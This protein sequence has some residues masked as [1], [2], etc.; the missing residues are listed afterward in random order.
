[1]T[2]SAPRPATSAPSRA[3]PP[4]IAELGE[5]GI[6]PPKK[7]SG[8]F[9]RYPEAARRRKVK[10][11]VT[12]SLVISEAGVPEEL[13]VVESAGPVLDQAVLDAVS[14]WRF[15]PATREGRPV[16]LRYRVRQHFRL[17]S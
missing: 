1:L 9:A 11:V 2:P 4:S 17:E 16:R 12:V 10:G 7:I 6:E 8:E 14:K 3:L 15:E 5:P 13:Q